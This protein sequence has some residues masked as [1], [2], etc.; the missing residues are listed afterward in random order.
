MEHLADLALQAEVVSI[1]CGLDLTRDVATHFL[2]QRLLSS[3][4]EL[5]R[6][7]H[8]PLVIREKGASDKVIEA[9]GQAGSASSSGDG[10]VGVADGQ[11]EWQLRVAIH[12]FSGSDA[13]L[14]AYVAAGFYIM[15]NGQV[16]A[17]RVDSAAGGRTEDADNTGQAAPL[18]LPE[19]AGEGAALFRQLRSGLLPLE[20][21]LLCS[22][23]PLHTPQNI[24]DVHVRSQRNE[25]ANLCFVYDIVAKAYRVPVEQLTQQLASNALTFYQLQHKSPATASDSAQ[26]VAETAVS[27]A[28][29]QHSEQGNKAASKAAK[30]SRQDGGSAQSSKKQLAA[31]VQ[32][33]AHLN[34]QHSQHSTARAAPL[35]RE[36]VSDEASSSEQ[37]EA[38][39]DSDDEDG[40]EAEEERQRAEGEQGREEQSRIDEESEDEDDDEDGSEQSQ[41]DDGSEAGE[42]AELSLQAAGRRNKSRHEAD[43]GANESEEGWSAGSK[44]KKKAAT[45]TAKAAASADTGRGR[46][47]RGQ[48]KQQSS[49]EVGRHGQGGGEEQKEAELQDDA[50][51]GVSSESRQQAAARR[52]RAVGSSAAGGGKSSRH[53]LVGGD[54]DLSLDRDILRYACRRCRTVLFS[55]D[56]VIPHASSGDAAKSGSSQAA[57]TPSSSALA[58]S[59]AGGGRK[60]ASLSAA[61][62]TH[63]ESTFIRPMAWMRNLATSSAASSN[64][65][66]GGG[67]GSKLSA[68][69]VNSERIECPCGAKLGRCGMMSLYM[70]CSCGRLCDGPPPYFAVHRSRVDT[71][72]RSQLQTLAA[73]RAADEQFSERV[74]EAEEEE[75]R[76][77]LSKKERERLKRD[78]KK[79]KRQTRADQ[80]GNFSE[81]RNLNLVH[82]KSSRA[83]EEETEAQSTKATSAT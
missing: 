54:V 15:L 34:I 17:L 36:S 7:I 40:E 23:A 65:S 13:Q 75:R 12:S 39:Q 55:E 49:S 22:D 78:N 46:Q 4:V 14:S 56:D 45:G 68:V 24:D 6:R 44:N 19:L 51:D 31:A 35:E 76:R 53:R 74:R 47:Q 26:A 79:V 3:Q 37:S 20:R 2:Q 59:A 5:A 70:P 57:S 33:M 29:P 52:Q 8:L 9:V 21:L 1:V 18:L 66:G 42:Q 25:P 83:E 48:N 77:Q 64:G 71:I 81:F 72:D 32:Q 62:L 69:L 58:S 10:A 60:K 43:S 73:P 38:E 11:S 67:S 30:S 82:S 50:K 63:C 16:T 61:E 28:Q 80:R 41:S 27:E